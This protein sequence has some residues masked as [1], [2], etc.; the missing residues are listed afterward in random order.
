MAEKAKKGSSRPKPTC[1]AKAVD[2]L[3][4]S[5]Q[6]KKRLSMKL[7]HAKYSED[8]IDEALERLEGKGYIREQESC[9][10]KFQNMYDAENCSVRQICVKLVQQG[11]ERDMVEDCIPDYTDE[12]EERAAYKI[13]SHKFKVGTEPKKMYQY[14]CSKG[15]Q[16]DVAQNTVEKLLSEWDFE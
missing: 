3:Y 16:Y 9:Q 4:R 14:L 11:Y 1:L 12:H 15:F 13:A 10:R 5:D 8:E 6:S 2:L 7:R